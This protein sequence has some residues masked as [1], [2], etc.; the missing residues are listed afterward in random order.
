MSEKSITE[1]VV[2]QKSNLDNEFYS[3]KDYK[4]DSLKSKLKTAKIAIQSTI[5][6][7]ELAPTNEAIRY[8]AFGYALSQTRNP[9]IGGAVLGGSTLIVEGGAALACADVLSSN[10]ANKV[11]EKINKTVH[12]IIPPEAKMSRLT[13]AGIALYGGS[14][15]VM[16]EKQREDPSRTMEDNRRYGLTTAGWLAGVLAVEGALISNGIENYNDP[17]SVGATLLAAG[18]LFAATKWAKN[19]LKSNNIPQNIPEKLS[20]VDG[21]IS[22]EENVKTKP[23]YDLS[24]FELDSL[25]KSLVSDI[26]KRYKQEGLYAA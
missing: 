25:E 13:E 1:Q 4:K 16:A 19:K 18:G 20:I 24:Q 15:I 23:R 8:G 5:I 14:V 10:K 21:E 3:E 7:M 17:K 6:A 22:V 9:L 11:I 26:E 2:D 12:K